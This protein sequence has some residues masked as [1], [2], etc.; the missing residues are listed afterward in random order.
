MKTPESVGW[1]RINE[2]LKKLDV[3]G[4]NH[5]SLGL[6]KESE[7]TDPE[8][9]ESFFEGMGKIL[10]IEN[11][12]KVKATEWFIYPDGKTPGYEHLLWP[13]KK[14]F[15]HIEIDVKD[16]NQRILEVF[17]E[18]FEEKPGMFWLTVEK[19]FLGILWAIIITNKR[20]K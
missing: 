5:F 11:P 13:G 12:K 18:A 9:I 2:G 14:V 17:P 15:Y 6:P 4:I 8:K 16:S 1:D 7:E 3:V 20:E 10:G 19:D